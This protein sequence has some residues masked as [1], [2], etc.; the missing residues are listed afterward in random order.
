VAYSRTENDV[1]VFDE[2]VIIKKFGDVPIDIRMLLQS[3]QKKSS[4][5]FPRPDLTT[6]IPPRC[7]IVMAMAAVKRRPLPQPVSNQRH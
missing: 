6:Y 3:N 7:H 2:A 4:P 5:G 1:C